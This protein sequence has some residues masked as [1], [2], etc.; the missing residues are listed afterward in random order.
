M[1][2]AQCMLVKSL[3]GSLMV[4]AELEALVSEEMVQAMGMGQGRWNLSPHT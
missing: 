3:Q 4:K 1:D 2:K